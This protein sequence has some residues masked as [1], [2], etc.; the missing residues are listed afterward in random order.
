MK[1]FQLLMLIIIPVCGFAQKENIAKML[2]DVKAKCDCTLQFARNDKPAGVS[3][4]LVPDTLFVAIAKETTGF[5]L[6]CGDSNIAYFK[7]QYEPGNY[8]YKL[9]GEMPCDK[10]ILDPQEKLFFSEEPETT[11]ITPTFN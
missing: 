5:F 7:F 6:T 1:K 10:A 9:T 2:F 11:S 4:V 8:I 3:Y